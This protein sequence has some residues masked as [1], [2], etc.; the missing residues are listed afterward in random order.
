MANLQCALKILSTYEISREQ[1]TIIDA[2]LTF[3]HAD[4]I[5]TAERQM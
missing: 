5:S 3:A 1:A 4:E 2:A